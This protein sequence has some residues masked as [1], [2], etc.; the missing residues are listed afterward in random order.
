MAKRLTF[1]DKPQHR[2]QATREY[3]NGSFIQGRS[4]D[5]SVHA[6]VRVYLRV[7]EVQARVGSQ[8]LH[9]ALRW[10]FPPPPASSHR[11]IIC[12]GPKLETSGMFHSRRTGA[13]NVTP[14]RHE[15]LLS[16]MKERTGFSH[17]LGGSCLHP[18]Q[19]L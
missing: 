4:D 1:G 2:L 14:A 8:T 18:L 13:R 3:S 15:T 9:Q 6:C 16:D 7:R 10:G 5:E 19:P 12:N 11:G 17:H